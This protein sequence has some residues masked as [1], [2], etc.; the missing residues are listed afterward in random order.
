MLAERIKIQKRCVQRAWE[1]DAAVNTLLNINR[2][3]LK[4]EGLTTKDIFEA[5][6]YWTLEERMISKKYQK[7]IMNVNRY[8]DRNAWSG[9]QDTPEGQEYFNRKRT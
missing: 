3:V 5:H 1:R 6:K 7:I 9:W 2:A 8:L 4:R